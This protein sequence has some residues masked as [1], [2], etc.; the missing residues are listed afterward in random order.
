MN[1][2]SAKL[3]QQSVTEQVHTVQGASVREFATPEDLLRHDRSQT[4]V[5]P[6]VSGRLADTIATEPKPAA[7]KPW[8][9]RLL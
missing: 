2:P 1:P 9:K 4:E 7:K 5:P 3:T 6:S 8:W